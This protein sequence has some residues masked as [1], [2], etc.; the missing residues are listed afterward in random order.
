MAERWTAPKAAN[1]LSKILA[2]FA[3]EHQLDRFPVDVQALALRAHEFFHWSDPIVEVRAADI[4]GFEGSLHANDDK[5]R[6]LL[7]YNSSLRSP[8][9]IR[10]TQAHELGHYILHR[11]GRESMSCTEEDMVNWSKDEA[12]LEGQADQFASYLLM[13][14][15]DYKAQV[16]GDITLDVFV[17]CAKRYGVSLIAAIL[18]W[19]D[20]TT[21]K[22]MLV[23]STDGFINWACSSEYARAAG[24]FIKTR[25][26]VVPLPPASLAADPTITSETKGREVAAS[27]WFPHAERGMTVREMKIVAERLGFVLSLVLLPSSAKV[28]PPWRNDRQ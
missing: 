8:G 24:A 10:F 17:A 11:L 1:R 15:D 27:V 23:Y 28:W 6:W 25:G 22:A 14:L 3:G 12:N 20:Y 19:L 26:T 9:R 21:D 5:T 7:L 18:K 4:P 13:P 2:H 16:R